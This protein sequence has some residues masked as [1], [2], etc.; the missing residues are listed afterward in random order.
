M[1]DKLAIGWSATSA[2]S[3]FLFFISD[4]SLLTVGI[5]FTIQ[6]L[7]FNLNKMSSQC[8]YNLL[9]TGLADWLLYCFFLIKW[10][11]SL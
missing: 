11:V 1:L 3:Y 7:G 9:Q 2:G 5:D 8:L 6:M 10:P 4:N